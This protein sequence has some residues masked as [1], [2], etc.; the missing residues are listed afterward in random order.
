MMARVRPWA[1]RGSDLDGTAAML[2]SGRLAATVDQGF[3]PD[4]LH[5]EDGETGTARRLAHYLRC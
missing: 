4:T 5:F 1:R 2:R 3:E